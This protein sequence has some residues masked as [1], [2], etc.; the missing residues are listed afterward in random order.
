MVTN[1]TAMSH[2]NVTTADVVLDVEYALTDILL[3]SLFSECAS[4]YEQNKKRWLSAMDRKLVNGQVDGISAQ[5]NDILTSG[6]R[7]FY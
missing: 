1:A 4:Y 7:Y 5:P 2:Q 3:K 6:T